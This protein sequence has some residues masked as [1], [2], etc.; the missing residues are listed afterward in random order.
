MCV[1]PITAIQFRA[2][3][4]A[5][6]STKIVPWI[7]DNLSDSDHIAMA[8]KMREDKKRE[9][10]EGEVRDVV[11]GC[12]QCHECRLRKSREWANRCVLEMDQYNPEDGVV[13]NWFVT[14]TYDPRFTDDLRSWKNPDILSL[15]DPNGH[16]RYLQDLKYQGYR[17]IGEPIE[18]VKPVKDHLQMFN[19]AIRK[20]WDEKYHHQGVRFYAC[21]EYGD[22][23]ARPHYHEI[24]FNLPIDP[25]RLKLR[26]TN[27][28]GDNYFTCDDLSASWGK[29]HI[30]LSE[31]NWTNAA[32][33]ARYIMKKLTGDLGEEAYTKVGLKPPFTRMSRRPGIG[34]EFYK[35]P[36]D[37]F[38][39]DDLDL[40][41]DPDTGEVLCD[42]DRALS[43][44]PVHDKIYLPSVN[45]GQDP[46]CRPPK[47]FDKMFQ[48]DFP[49][50]FKVIQDKR[51]EILERYQ[52]QAKVQYP[53]SD[54][55]LFSLKAEKWEKDKKGFHRKFIQ[56]I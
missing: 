21:G 6:W 54:R 14:L 37:Y 48:R 2:N 40:Q 42:P 47:Y 46:T 50:S 4:G 3:P 29:G 11:F 52:R 8:A 18:D 30:L 38:L 23:S 44:M 55:E 10:P 28:F 41:I 15:H 26:F 19:N 17:R 1:K 27:Q 43:V 9:F 32:Y 22:E 35:G 12:G 56:E 51:K 20:K 13:K 49:E 36:E 39:I 34:G 25:D 53:I 16:A 7:T 33:V 24:L 5:K 45:K 31:A